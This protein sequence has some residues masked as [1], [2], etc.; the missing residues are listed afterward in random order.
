[1][2]GDDAP[3]GEEWVARRFAELAEEI[4][5]LSRSVPESFAPVVKKLQQTIIETIEATTRR[6]RRQLP[7]SRRQCRHHRVPSQRRARCLGRRSAPQVRLRSAP[8]WR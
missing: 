1:M 3:Q 2:L 5:E 4:G 6:R 8:P 7:R